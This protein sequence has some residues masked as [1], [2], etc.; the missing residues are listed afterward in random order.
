M[1]RESH[2]AH[3]ELVCAL[4]Q[5]VSWADFVTGQ[6]LGELDALSLTND[7]LVVLHSEYT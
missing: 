6:I 3:L 1:Q 7:T 5:A 4:S 2:V